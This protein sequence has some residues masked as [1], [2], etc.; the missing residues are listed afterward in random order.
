MIKAFI[1]SPRMVMVASKE[2]KGVR[3]IKQSA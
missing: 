3:K 2:R 1:D